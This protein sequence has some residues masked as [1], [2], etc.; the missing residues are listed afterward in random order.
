M[1]SISKRMLF[2]ILSLGTRIVLNGVRWKYNVWSYSLY[3]LSNQW[4]SELSTNGLNCWMHILKRR[5]MLVTFN[6]PIV[7]VEHT[8]VTCVPSFSVS[9][10]SAILVS[11]MKSTSASRRQTCCY[12]TLTCC[13]FAIPAANVQRP[14]NLQESKFKKKKR[15]NG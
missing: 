10:T 13:C 4:I 14:M 1:E 12:W 15:K 2:T 5:A 9:L 7:S 3:T 8:C 6:M 11:A